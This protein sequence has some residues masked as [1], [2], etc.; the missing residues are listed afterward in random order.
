MPLGWPENCSLR[1]CLPLRILA[2]LLSVPPPIGRPLHSE[3]NIQYCEKLYT[4]HLLQNK[5]SPRATS[6]WLSLPCGRH[7]RPAHSPGGSMHRMQRSEPEP[8]RTMQCSGI[9]GGLI[10][11]KSASKG[12]VSGSLPGTCTAQPSTRTYAL[13]SCRL[14]TRDLA[15]LSRISGAAGCQR[16]A[17]RARTSAALLPKFR[18]AAILQ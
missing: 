5:P 14:K 2:S 4:P 17:S 12:V 15:R 16:A 13:H 6:E 9:G 7:G 1:G 11:G 3:P 10:L 18:N 8:S